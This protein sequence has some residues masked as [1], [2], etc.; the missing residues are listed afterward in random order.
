MLGWGGYP[1]WCLYCNT[2]IC[3]SIILF[4]RILLS[5]IFMVDDYGGLKTEVLYGKSFESIM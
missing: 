3:I 1:A 4:V 5:R 2:T